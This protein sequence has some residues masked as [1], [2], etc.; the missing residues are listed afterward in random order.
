MKSVKSLNR[1]TLAHAIKTSQL[2]EFAMYQ[3]AS[4]V[5]PISVDIFDKS[6][7]SVVKERKLQDQ[8]SGLPLHDCLSGKKT[9]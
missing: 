1:L 6:V 2:Q 9:R 4:G 3:E 7:I 8:T 5:S